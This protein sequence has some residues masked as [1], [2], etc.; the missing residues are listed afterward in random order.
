MRMGVLPG[1][2]MI[3]VPGGGERLI[4]AGVVG[5]ELRGLV[6]K[7][8]AALGGVDGLSPLG[9]IAI[10]SFAAVA[11]ADLPVADR[12]ITDRTI[13]GS[14]GGKSAVRT[15]AR[16]ASATAAASFNL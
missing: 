7:L 11:A 9:S 15:A 10:A 6:G 13:G 14:P 16:T 4:L 8:A 12:A 1:A 3:G 2:R 5:F